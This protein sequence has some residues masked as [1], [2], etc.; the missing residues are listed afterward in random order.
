MKITFSSAALLQHLNAASCA[1]GKKNSMPILDCFL[2]EIVDDG[3][4]VNITASDGENVFTTKAPLT[5]YTPDE[6]PTQT[7]ICI[8]AKLL[9]DALKGLPE[10]PVTLTCNMQSNEVRGDYQGGHFVI[11]GVDAATYPVAPQLNVDHQSLA[12]P[13]ALVRSGIEHTLFATATDEIRLVM[14]GV[15]LDVAPENVTFV[16]TNGKVLV[17]RTVH[18]HTGQECRIILPKKVCN[19]LRSVLSTKEGDTVAIAYDVQRA[20][21]LGDQFSLTARLVEGRYPNYAGVIPQ[22]PP[23][24]ATL[25]SSDLT[26][27]L[28]RIVNF[29]DQGSG[30]VRFDFAQDGLTLHGHDLTYATSGEERVSCELSGKDEVEI[31]L[32]GFLC[33][34]VIKNLGAAELTILLTDPTHPVVFRPIDEEEDVDMLMLLMPMQLP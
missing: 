8:G 24:R 18:C 19:I 1:I 3:Q 12:L 32:N 9:T 23:A 26:Q 30:L 20:T 16:G 6:D 10:Q 5:A 25:S 21:F 27:A 15:L 17:R 4:A 7:R 33:G 29:A 14:T 22:N 28:R 34:E 13:S 11:M 2:L 31:G